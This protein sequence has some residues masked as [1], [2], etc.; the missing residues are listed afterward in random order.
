MTTTLSVGEKKESD[1]DEC[2]WLRGAS[3]SCMYMF[4]KFVASNTLATSSCM[5]IMS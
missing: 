1:D 2:G 3:L 4:V 5:E